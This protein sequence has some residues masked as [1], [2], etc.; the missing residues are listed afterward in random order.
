MADRFSK[1]FL[2]TP[3][4]V[5]EY[6]TKKLNFFD[7][8]STLTVEEIGDGNINYVFKVRDEKS[9]KSIVIKQADALL[10]SSQ[11]PLSL[12]RSKIEAEVLKIQGQLAPK[13]VPKVYNYDENLCAIAMEDISDYKNLRTEMLSG[14]TFDNLAQ[15]ISSFMVDTLLSTTDLVL[16]R[17]EKKKRTADFIN[18]EL[19][20]ISE[21]LVFTEPYHNYKNRNI[22]TD[23]NL[24]FVKKELYD[25]LQ[26][27]AEIGALRNNFMNNP[28]SLIHGDLHSG[29]IFINQTGIKV[30]DPEF[31][32]YGPMGYDVGNVLGNMTIGLVRGKIEGIEADLSD[33]A[34]KSIQ[35]TFDMFF[36]KLEDKFDKLVEFELYKN[37]QFKN[38]YIKSVFCDSVGYSGTE[39]IRRT[40]GDSKVKEI[41]SVTNSKTRA[42]LEKCLVLIGKELVIKRSN[43]TSGIQ[44]TDEIYKILKEV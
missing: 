24:D 4:D 33:W 31:A 13:F 42:L 19:C 16:D 6:A 34:K 39:I 26:L 25:D 21:D 32:F 14:K 40:V 22:I 5:R 10:R 1:H 11:R 17:G 37:Q 41:T 8:D 35:D 44:F 2:M 3:D 36:A 15:D 28:Q 38:R 20:D 23:Q 29:S 18:I 30:I 9:K 43:I 7:V 27:K 12:Q